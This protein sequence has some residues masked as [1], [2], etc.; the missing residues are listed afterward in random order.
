MGTFVT[1]RKKKS[2]NGGKYSG[3]SICDF[4]FARSSIMTGKAILYE[5]ICRVHDFN[6]LNFIML[7][8]IR[9]TYPL[10]KIKRYT[11]MN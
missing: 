1:Q 8:K 9:K 2:I 6:N 10:P 5:I 11:I 3:R 4:M 7:F